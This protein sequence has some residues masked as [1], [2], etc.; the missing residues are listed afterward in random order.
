[1][2]LVRSP[3][4]E[5]FL[6]LSK[7]KVAVC[8]EPALRPGEENVLD[9]AVVVLLLLGDVLQVCVEDEA[10]YHHVGRHEQPDVDHLV[11]NINVRMRAKS[12]HNKDYCLTNIHY[13]YV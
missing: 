7:T 5:F 6:D 12:E 13:H 10:V 3:H 8:S 1:M 9:A 2:L 4:L 11:N